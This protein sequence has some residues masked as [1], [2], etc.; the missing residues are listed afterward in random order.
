MVER[1]LGGRK[2]RKMR[3]VLA[4]GEKGLKT[5]ETSVMNRVIIL[6]D[7]LQRMVISILGEENRYVTHLVGFEGIFTTNTR[8]ILSSSTLIDALHVATE[9]FPSLPSPHA[10][11]RPKLEARTVCQLSRPLQSI[12]MIN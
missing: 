12:A 5:V 6:G 11:A 4:F 7:W 9:T 10:A 1:A 2:E 3:A 8:G